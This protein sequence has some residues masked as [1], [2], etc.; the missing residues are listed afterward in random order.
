[1][2]SHLG[3]ERPDLDSRLRQHP[4]VGD[5]DD[6]HPRPALLE[7]E[8][9]VGEEDGATIL[10]RRQRDGLLD[11]RQLRGGAFEAG[12]AG[13]RGEGRQGD[14]DGDGVCVSGHSERFAVAA[15][16]RATGT[17]KAEQDT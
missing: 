8:V 11:P 14:G 5:V 17:R 6:D 13:R 3:R 7:I 16:N 1:M 15:A 9:A 12:L 10:G 4:A 2:Q